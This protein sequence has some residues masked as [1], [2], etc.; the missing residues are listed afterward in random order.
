MNAVVLCRRFPEMSDPVLID[1][2]LRSTARVNSKLLF[3][4]M[5]KAYQAYQAF[6]DSLAFRLFYD[7]L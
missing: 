6:V 3:F 5:T 2:T 1:L 7:I 4:S